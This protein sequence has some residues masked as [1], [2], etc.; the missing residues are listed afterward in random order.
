ME[1]I[2]HATIQ[3][4]LDYIQ[5]ALQELRGY[6]AG[7]FEEFK[8]DRRTHNAAAY[9]LQTA[10]EAVTD[11]ANHLVAALGLGQPKERA[12]SVMFLAQAEILSNDLA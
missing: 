4:R 8:R 1:M 10:V 9:Q 6:R 3:R 2:D 12:D 11:I 5:T 7:S